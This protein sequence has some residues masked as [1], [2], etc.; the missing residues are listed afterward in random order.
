MLNIIGFKCVSYEIIEISDYKLNYDSIL[1][2]F[3]LKL[4]YFSINGSFG[5]NCKGD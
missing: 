3:G 4:G 1:V 2:I 5:E